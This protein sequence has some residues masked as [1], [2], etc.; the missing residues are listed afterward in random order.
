MSN[1]PSWQR[2]KYVIVREHGTSGPFTHRPGPA[3]EGSHV[4]AATSLQIVLY[5]L[6]ELATAVW[7]RDSRQPTERIW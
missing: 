2:G 3:A 7:G 5:W 6:A 4:A 1:R